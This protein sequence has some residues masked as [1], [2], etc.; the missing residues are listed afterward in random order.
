MSVEAELWNIFTFYTLHGNPL[1]P[2]HLRVCAPVSFTSLVTVVAWR[3]HASG[4][5]RGRD[6]RARVPASPVRKTR[7]SRADDRGARAHRRRSS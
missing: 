6:G 7:S 5:R 4:S 1:D 2:E 3:E